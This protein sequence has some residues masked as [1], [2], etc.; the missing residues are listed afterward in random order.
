M[1]SLP[2]QTRVARVC[3]SPQRNERAR[4]RRPAGCDTG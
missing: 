1:G 2:F 4:T 3:R